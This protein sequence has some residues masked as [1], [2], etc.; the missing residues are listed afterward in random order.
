MTGAGTITVF[1]YSRLNSLA[2][3]YRFSLP[4]GE[5]L[6]LT[7]VSDPSPL[8]LSMG[9]GSGLRVSFPSTRLSSAIL[10]KLNYS[11]KPDSLSV[12]VGT[13]YNSMGVE[14]YKMFILANDLSVRERF[15]VST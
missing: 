3:V 5:S 14:F 8:I 4:N 9:D 6:I 10:Q 15:Y 2:S 12:D 13:E 11:V 7:S 1:V